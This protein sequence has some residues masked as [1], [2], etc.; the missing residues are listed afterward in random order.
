LCWVVASDH[1][2]HAAHPA[3]PEKPDATHQRRAPTAVDQASLAT[4]GLRS[5][6]PRGYGLSDGVL[7]NLDT[8]P[9]Q[10]EIPPSRGFKLANHRGTHT[11][12]VAQVR[13][14]CA[15][16]DGGQAESSGP[17][18][19]CRVRWLCD[20]WRHPKA[21]WRYSCCRPLGADLLSAEQGQ[22]LLL[23][24]R[25]RERQSLVAGRSLCRCIHAAL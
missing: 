13:A 8:T 19:E 12:P 6:L 22:R 3:P 4:W 9:L 11:T 16:G 7:V 14:I 21:L 5:R 15:L 1:R 24:R 25:T 20:L 23:M 10:L 2:G 17:R 18:N